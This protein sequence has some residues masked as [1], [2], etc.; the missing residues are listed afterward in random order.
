MLASDCKADK[1]IFYQDNISLGIIFAVLLLHNNKISYTFFIEFID[2][3]MA[4][5]PWSF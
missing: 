5:T 4:I 2:E 1:S 3:S